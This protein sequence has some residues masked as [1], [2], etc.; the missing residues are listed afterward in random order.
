MNFVSSQICPFCFCALSLLDCSNILIISQALDYVY[1]K[2]VVDW[3][4]ARQSQNHVRYVD[5]FLFK[6][7]FIFIISTFRVG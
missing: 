5:W 3:N 4:N 7:F 6:G 2:V 1:N